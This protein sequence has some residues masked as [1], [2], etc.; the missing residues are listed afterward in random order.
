MRGRLYIVGIGPGSPG[1]RTLDMIEAI[2]RSNVVIG[3]KT[4]VDLIEDLL[5]GKEVIRTRMREEVMR[6]NLALERA[7]RGDTV[8][9][10]SSGDPQVY[11]MASLVFEIMSRRGIDVDVVVIPGVTA[12][13]AAAAKLGSPLGMDFAVISLSDLLIPQEEILSRVARAAEG[14][15]VLALYN[16]INDELLVRAMDVISQYRSPRTPVGIVRGAYRSNEEVV[17]TDLGGWRNYLGMIDMVTT[18]IVGNSQSYIHN[19][20]I[21]TPRGYSRKY[22]IG[23]ALFSDDAP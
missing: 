1:L 13:L 8:A 15:F 2:R 19:G 21:I 4:Y 10:V 17:V 23:G 14:D 3:Y 11:G 9:L 22:D 5:E 12:A 18:I 7:A 6:A 16:P 20:R